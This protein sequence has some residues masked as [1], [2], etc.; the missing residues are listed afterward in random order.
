VAGLVLG[1]VGVAVVAM[2]GGGCSSSAPPSDAGLALPACRGEAFAGAPLGIRCGAFVDSAGREVFLHG[3]NARVNGLFDVTFDDGRTALE[4]IPELTAA[5]VANMRSVGFNALRLPLNWS[6]LEPTEAGGF[7]PSYLARISEVVGLAR[8]AG[9][10]VLLDMHQ[11]AYSK[12]IG[13]DGAP[14]WAIVPPPPEKLQGPL[15]DLEARR[16]SKPVAAAFETFFGPAQDGARLRSRFARAVREIAQRFAD[17]P[18]VVGL[19]AFNEPLATEAA[20]DVFHAEIVAAVREV[21]PKMLV[22]FE[23]SAVRNLT[24]RASL[25]TKPL[26][27]GT[28]YAPHVYTLAFT[29]TE[30]SVAAMTKETLRPSNE[31]ARLEADAWGTPLVVGE[32]G[33]S[34]K[35]PRFAD[36]VA[37]QSELQE[38]VHAS[39]FFWLWKEDS[40]GAW[41]LYD[42]TVEGWKERPD[43]IAALTRLRLE[44]VA[45][46]L[47]KVAYD[48]AAKKLTF[49]FEGVSGATGEA[50]KSVV[51]TGRFAGSLSVTCDGKG[52]AAEG[53]GPIAIPCGGAGA[54]EV[55]VAQLP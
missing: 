44:R 39:S 43:V 54:H 49:S 24:D 3:V 14:Y 51:S 21:A 10:L 38:E 28:V 52:I 8:D 6:G 27:P 35:S 4:P 55:V 2:H 16:L 9:L 19:E 25:P 33:F 18:A 12:E 42:R 47:E 1:A 41:G 11:D 23:P 26:G 7:S 34:P 46:R 48:R 5:D 20:L 29:G 30:A 40:Q 37:F 15:L 22:F 45:G 36:Y 53:K 17:D 13:E 32:F 50:T 31:N